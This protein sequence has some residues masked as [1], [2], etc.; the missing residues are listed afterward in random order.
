MRKLYVI[1]T[2]VLIHDPECIYKFKGNDVAI[3]IFVIVELDDLKERKKGHVAFAS[4]VASRTIQSIKGD[5]G[6]LQTGVYLTEEDITV[7]VIGTTG[8]VGIQAL[9]ENN[10]PRK[11]DLWIMQSALEMKEHYDKVILVSKDLNLR[12]LSQGEGL[13]AEDYENDKISLKTVHTGFRHIGE[14]PI[15]PSIYNPELDIPT[16]EFIEEPKPNEFYLGTH[17]GKKFVIQNVDGHLRPVLKNFQGT[18]RPKNIEQRMAMALLMSED[19]KLVSLIG[20]AG[21]G[22]TI[23]ALASAITQLHNPYE[24]IVL[25]K[26][27]VDMG[28]SLGFLPGDKD[29]KMAPWIA[30]YFDNLD[31]IIPSKTTINKKTEPNWQYLFD[32]QSLVIQPLNS[33]RGRSIDNAFMIIDEAQNLTPH[34]IKTIITRAG[35]GTKVVIM[36]DPYQVDNPFLDQNSNGLT[37]VTEKM[38]SSKI[39]GSVL[40]SKGVRSTLAEEAANL[41]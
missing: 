25:S 35:E 10:N 32:T 4:R 29:E 11:M 33:I 38:K 41:L 24:Q 17:E 7:K 20:K 18:I 36:G 37:Y 19:I 8:G 6:D 5:D 23:I 26:P 22:K 39:F 3:P 16:H 27:I 1:D 21:T 31:K 40:F 30:S 28:N 34:E 13:D 12:L 14:S 15:F 2:S 9:Q